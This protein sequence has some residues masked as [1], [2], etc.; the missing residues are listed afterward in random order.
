M[1]TKIQKTM[2]RY[3]ELNHNN[4][5]RGSLLFCT[6]DEIFLIRSLTIKKMKSESQN[7]MNAH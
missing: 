7:L 6:F 2:L 4:I 3:L 5:E 1:Q